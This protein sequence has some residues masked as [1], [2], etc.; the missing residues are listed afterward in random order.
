MG[1]INQGTIDANQATTLYIQTSAGTTNSGTLEATA[2]GNLNLDGDTYTNSG[3]ILATG[4]NSVV[5]LQNPTIN[6]G[7]LQTLLGGVIS[8]SGNPTLN[9][10]T[11][12]G[13]GS[14]QL[15]NAQQTILV[16]TITNR[17]AIQLN[18][19][20]SNTVL[21]SSGAVTLT[22]G[23]TVTLSDD[24]SNI[25]APAVAGSSLTNVN[26]TISG[27]GDIGNGSMAFTNDAA[28]IV[29][30]TSSHNNALTIAP[31]A[32]AVTNLV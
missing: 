24:V 23:G 27:S 20:N 16:G 21:W 22:G 18:A 15:P 12:T 8:A 4:A 2:G 19:T 1:L 5:T 31:G 13:T 26:N 25:L 7:T 28:G 14:Y 30:A 6:G 17:G 32:A 3:T 11:N 10:V 9:G 29:N